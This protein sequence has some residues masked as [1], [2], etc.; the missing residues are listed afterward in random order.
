MDRS[1][2]PGRRCGDTG[3]PISTRRQLLRSLAIVGTA[4]LS[5][6]C[7]QSASQTVSRTA[8]ST[9]TSRSSSARTAPAGKRTALNV[10]YWGS[11][12][13]QQCYKALHAGFE[14]THPSITLQMNPGVGGVPYYQKLEAMAAG[15]TTPDVFRLAPN[16][17]ASLAAKQLPATLDPY[18]AAD[19]F[20]LKQ[21]WSA[22]VQSWRYNGK[23]L[24]MPEIG[25]VLVLLYNVDLFK[26]A[27]V[28]DPNTANAAKQWTWKTFVTA[29]QR[30][31]QGN[32]ATKQF[33]CSFITAIQQLLPWIW[34]A[35]GRLFA[36][37]AHPTKL[38][39]SD[40]HTVAAFQWLADLLNKYRVAPPPSYTATIS[41]NILFYT[42]RLGMYA[43]LTDLGTVR[44]QI[45]GKFNWD[46]GPLPA[47]PAGHVN[48]AGG[49]GWALANT[50]RVHDQGWLVLAYIASKPGQ[51]QY[52]SRQLEIPVLKTLATGAWLKLPPP[53]VHRQPI[54]AALHE[55]RPIPKSPQMLQLA[56]QA[57]NPE[58]DL[59]WSGKV[60]AKTAMAAIDQKG[61]GL[62]H[63]S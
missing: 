51:E 49:A 27:G 43:T 54:L 23:L 4:L 62:L 15:G 29:A 12:A 60:D 37:D 26:K 5:A 30:L 47:G 41:P 61:N 34:S 48:F 22:L 17:F 14:Q 25:N 38:D 45:N 21:Y 59:L 9:I 39:M 63:Q 46:V 28:T 24:S 57:I 10:Y 19:K 1:G 40:P 3:S 35:G 31:T 55:A 58:L 2:A 13:E 56:A 11:L 42:G 33:G 8:A 18:V 52:V 36:D 6:A 53:P 32:G 16:W 50:S 7:A 44:Q 20:P